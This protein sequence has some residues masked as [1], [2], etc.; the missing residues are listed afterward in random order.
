MGEYQ[1]NYKGDKTVAGLK[2]E[3]RDYY[4]KLMGD[5]QG[6]EKPIWSNLAFLDRFSQKA[7]AG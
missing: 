1:N 3:D 6:S 2:D 7:V 4:N 5:L